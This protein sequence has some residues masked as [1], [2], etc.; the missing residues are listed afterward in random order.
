MSEISWHSFSIGEAFAKLHSKRDG[1]TNREAERR[2]A[3]FGPNKIIVEER[4]GLAR[5]FLR[6]IKSPL[7]FLLVL[8]GAVT[9]LVGNRADTIVIA[10]AIAANA[11]IGFFYEYRASRSLDE[12]RRRQDFFTWVRRDGNW[13]ELSVTA[14]V[15]GD[16]F[17]LRPGDI[18]PADG[19]I[20]TANNLIVDEAVLTGESNEVFK[21][22][23]QIP[24]AER[25]A[26][27][28]NMVWAGTT[29]LDGTAEVLVVAT[30]ER[31][32]FGKIQAVIRKTPAPVTPFEKKI[33]K[34]SRFLAIV[35]GAIV[36][37]LF[38]IGIKLGNGFAET[39]ELAIA[40]A[41]SAVPEGLPIAVTVILAIGLSRIL[42]NR[43]LVKR[44]SA[45]EVLGSSSVIL[46][47]K[48]GTL[49]LGEMSV[50]QV[51]VAARKHGSTEFIET[52]E[53]SSLYRAVLEFSTLTVDAI[54]ENPHDPLVDWRVRGRPTERA[55][56][57]AA[58]AS[59]VPVNELSRDYPLLNSIPFTSARKFSVSFRK[60]GDKMFGFFLGAPEVLLKHIRRIEFP[61]GVLA[62]TKD[63]LTEIKNAV[64]SMANAGFR[65]LLVGY[66]I[67]ANEDYSK[68]GNDGVFTGLVGLADPVR[69]DV[70]NMIQVARSAGIRTVMVTGDH[71]LTARNVAREIKLLPAARTLAT[72]VDG[73]ELEKMSQDELVRR[74]GSIDIFARVSPLQKVKIVKAWRATGAVVAMSGDGVNDAPALAQ[75]DVGIAVGT[76]TDIAKDTADI[77]LL[78]NSFTTIIA[79]VREG[80]VILENLKKVITY[81][82]ADSFTEIALIAVSFIGG[83]PLPVLA[84]QILW[85]NLI[86]D[87]LPGIALAFDPPEANI[88]KRPPVLAQQSLISKEMR[89]IIGAIGVFTTLSLTA[90]F[91]FFFWGGRD[92]ELTRTIIFVG[93][94]VNS[95]F[96]VFSLRSF[97][98]PLWRIRFW[99]NRRLL[100]AVAIGGVL[101]VAAVYLRPLQILLHTQALGKLEWIIL[102]GFGI[103]NIVAIE[104][105]KWLFYRRKHK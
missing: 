30:G 10:V 3:S 54:I 51:M 7:V 71:V 14:L 57:K 79:A 39:L 19:R 60:H 8:A 58:A 26:D 82:L 104:T 22:T 76:G 33:A 15:P 96:Y 69:K 52:G 90:L 94:A 12:L 13:Q 55:I 74:I 37:A 97:R 21:K 2:L 56:I 89:F 91:L 78:D 47:D 25:L 29:A 43:G 50:G 1:L 16:I 45:T 62:A 105:A 11:A 81:L 66:F 24:A 4:T 23:I 75:A 83:W 49:T 86:E 6:Q 73:E 32:E 44:L 99:K 36:L 95:L 68:I 103:L 34:L 70:P 59:N 40:L 93:L 18:V 65:V 85:V 88:M 28:T 77:V 5:V 46:T 101:V 41:V 92:I 42:A 84:S 63:D 31:S 64:N 80:R 98:Q 102:T 38:G 61:N 53:N 72:V 48:T 9:F 67:V 35:I 100:G 17:R 87:S 27:R 20:F